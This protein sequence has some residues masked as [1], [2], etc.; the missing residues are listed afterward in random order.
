LRY[1]LSNRIPPFDRLLLVESGSRE[2][3]DRLIPLLRLNNPHPIAIDVV[4]CYPGQPAGLNEGRVYRVAD[5]S[6]ATARWRLLNELAARGYTNLGIVCSGQPVMTQWKWA[7]AARLPAKV[8]LINENADYLYLD[9]AHR[10]NLI[11]LMKMR[12]G[13][14]GGALAPALA[15][16][17]FFPF[18]LVYLLLFAAAVHLRRLARGL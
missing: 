15:R 17:V 3:L 6:S 5:Y 13:L 1:L 9:R 18:A 2:I 11:V 12:L 8:F 10:R 14:G 7:I 4:T 16:L